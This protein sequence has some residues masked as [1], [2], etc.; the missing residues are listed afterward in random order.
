MLLGKTYG[1]VCW[2]LN[3]PE[4]R[5]FLAK[6]QRVLHTRYE[7]LRGCVVYRMISYNLYETSKSSADHQIV[8]YIWHKLRASFIEQQTA[9]YVIAANRYRLSSFVLFMLLTLTRNVRG[10]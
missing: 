2:I 8:S 6:F 9:L 4:F 10:R 3:P 5:I 7:I 1:S